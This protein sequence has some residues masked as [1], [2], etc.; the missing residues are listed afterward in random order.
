MTPK[1]ALAVHAAAIAQTVNTVDNR[2]CM[3]VLKF[4]NVVVHLSVCCTFNIQNQ[5]LLIQ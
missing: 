4:K 1:N 5:V 3:V 2:N